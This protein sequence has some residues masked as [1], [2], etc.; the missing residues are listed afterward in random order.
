MATVYYT[1][2][3]VYAV[4]MAFSLV[5]GIWLVFSRKFDVFV[6][7]AFGFCFASY[8]IGAAIHSSLI[9]VRR[10]LMPHALRL[11]RP[12]RYARPSPFPACRRRPC[13]SSTCSSCPPF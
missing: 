4:M 12:S 8:I 3:M 6:G 1:I 10:P 5:L 11:L 13:S 2:A 9:S 7:I